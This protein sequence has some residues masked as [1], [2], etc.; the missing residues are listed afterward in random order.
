MDPIT[1]TVN[2]ALEMSGLGRTTLYSL[3]ASSKIETVTVGRRRL[4]K[5]ASLRAMLEAA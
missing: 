5:V 3:I 2:R 1:V 4:V